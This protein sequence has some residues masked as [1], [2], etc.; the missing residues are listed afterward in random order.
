[1]EEEIKDIISW[2]RKYNIE[3][4]D[5]NWGIVDVMESVKIYD[6]TITK[7]PIKFGTIVGSFICAQNPGLTDLE[8][9]P[10]IVT[11][12]FDCAECNLTSLYGAPEQVGGYF[13]CEMNKL[14][15]LEYLPEEIGGLLYIHDNKFISDDLFYQELENLT[16]GKHQ[17]L[18]TIDQ[19]G[20]ILSDEMKDDFFN[21]I[22]K[23]NR[24]NTL[25]DIIND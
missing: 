6:P 15:T 19:V 4:Y 18:Q 21:W 25:N 3:N 10:R 13:A 17:N 22:I 16:N 5:I 11:G 8:N 14:T 9:A 12:I 23:K 24:L 7:I 1:M 20:N 2:L